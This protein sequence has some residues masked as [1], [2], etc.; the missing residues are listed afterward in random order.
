MYSK[1]MAQLSYNQVLSDIY[2][3]TAR[4]LYVYQT[5]YSDDVD[6]NQLDYSNNELTDPE[7]FNEYFGDRGQP[8]H[9]IQPQANDVDRDNVNYSRSVRTIVLNVDTRFRKNASISGSVEY[10]PLPGGLKC[11]TFAKSV[12]PIS[13]FSFNLSRL[14]KNITTVKLTSVEFNN[15]FYTF[16]TS[17]G[18]TSFTIQ[19]N[20]TVIPITIPDGNY[21]VIYNATTPTD[22]TTLIGIIQ[23]QLTAT[24]ITINYDITTDTVYFTTSSV[25]NITI[26]FP[27]N[28]LGT[29][30]G[31]NEISYTSLNSTTNLYAENS[32][33]P[34]VDEY[35]YIRVNDWDLLHHESMNQTYF[36]SLAKI[37]LPTTKNTVVFDSNYTNSSTK[38]YKF[39]KPINIQ[40]LDVSVLDS[41]GII[42]NLRNDFSFTL[43]LGQVNDSRVFEK[44]LE[45]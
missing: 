14:Y 41:N 34:I 22:T 36:Y 2:E 44:L 29:V 25:I 38:Q 33:D 3:E 6:E 11:I 16:S 19:T 21:P 17:R 27:T 42:L 20:T 45:D 31:F 18:N 39:E 15:S 13:N 12:V 8:D 10:I 37:Q 9:V 23:S 24:S 35:I 26:L 40:R 32:P 4:D 7:A 43:E 5:E 1:D 30:L 28:G